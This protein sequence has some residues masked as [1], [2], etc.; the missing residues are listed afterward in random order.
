MS[1]NDLQEKSWNCER[2][3]FELVE[4]EKDTIGQIIDILN[5][6]FLSLP[7]NWESNKSELIKVCPRCDSYPLGFG[8][9]QEFSIHTRSGNKS[10]INDLDFVKAHKNSDYREEILKSEIC[11][12]FYC[13]QT[14]SPDQILEWWGEE[15]SGV[16]PTAVCP[17]CGVDSVIGDV[18]GFPIEPT[19]LSVMRDFWFSPCERFKTMGDSAVN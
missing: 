4:V 13:T 10:T 1:I 3:D 5:P 2:C 11:G 14:F 12:C 7:T 15:E 9:E 16:D 17:K 18:S 6:N 19:F 8:M